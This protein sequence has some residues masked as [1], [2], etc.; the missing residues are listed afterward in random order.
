MNNE[1][2]LIKLQNEFENFRGLTVTKKQLRAIKKSLKKLD[3]EWL[4]RISKAD[5]PW[6]SLAA[7]DLIDQNSKLELDQIDRETARR[8][9]FK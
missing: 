2:L 9:L 1:Q 6:V 7:Q 5:I 4:T 3:A 8:L